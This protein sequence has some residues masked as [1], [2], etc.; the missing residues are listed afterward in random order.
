MKEDIFTKKDRMEPD[1]RKRTKDFS[2]LSPIQFP[3]N[4]Q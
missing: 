4:Q 3:T 2:F 1:T